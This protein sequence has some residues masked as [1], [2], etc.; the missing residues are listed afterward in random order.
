[1]SRNT[2]VVLAILLVLGNSGLSAGA[3]A[4]DGNYGTGREGVGV[5]GNNF[6][7]VG[8]APGDGYDGTATAPAFARV[9]W[10][11]CVGPLGHLLWAHNSHDLTWDSYDN[12]M[13]R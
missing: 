3:F 9:S 6:G 4:R 7:C 10:P 5:R 1:M 12:Y 2:T 11:R 13:L 8:G